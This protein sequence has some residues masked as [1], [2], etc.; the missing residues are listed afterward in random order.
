[1]KIMNMSR[2]LL[3]CTFALGFTVA[4]IAV[5]PKS[6]NHDAVGGCEHCYG[7]IEGRN[8]EDVSNDHCVNDYNKCAYTEGE[9]LE[10]NFRSSD[11]AAIAPPY[12]DECSR[13]R[14]ATN[15]PDG[16]ED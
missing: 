10:C 12:R 14:H 15:C 4:C 7:I 9:P 2:V 16:P 5:A 11:C 1:M 13:I 3:F 8:C 6:L